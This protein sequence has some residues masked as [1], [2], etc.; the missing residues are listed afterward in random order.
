MST[1]E[2]IKKKLHEQFDLKCKKCNSVNIEVWHVI[3]SDDVQIV[4]KNCENTWVGLVF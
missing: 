4:C 3:D 1:D 2:E